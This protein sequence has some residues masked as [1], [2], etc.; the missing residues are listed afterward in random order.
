MTRIATH[1]NLRRKK[2][3]EIAEDLDAIVVD[4]TEDTHIH[5]PTN[6]TEV[7]DIAM[8]KNICWNYNIEVKHQLTSDH[9]PVKLKINLK[10]G[11]RVTTRTYKLGKV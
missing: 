4:P 10:K 7:L 11:E 6:S 8:L 5:I 2:L 9:L 1:S 3:K